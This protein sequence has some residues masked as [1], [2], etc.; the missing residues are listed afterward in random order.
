MRCRQPK[1]IEPFVRVC[2]WP[3]VL[4]L[5]LIRALSLPGQDRTV[6]HISRAEQLRPCA[7]DCNFQQTSWCSF[8]LDI[9][10][11]NDDDNG[12]LFVLWHLIN[13]YYYLLPPHSPAGSSSGASRVQHSAQPW[14]CW[15]CYSWLAGKLATGRLSVPR[16]GR[17][18]EV[19][20]R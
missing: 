13:T 10:C 16:L 15:R 2:L 17:P 12:H 19:L 7:C 5:L 1:F 14:P 20:S 8:S 11:T 18:V 6:D 9:V 4:I 3:R